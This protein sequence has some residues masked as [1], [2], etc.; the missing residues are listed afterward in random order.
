MEFKVDFDKAASDAL[1]HS[2]WREFYNAGLSAS[3]G[4]DG[5]KIT[6][7]IQNAKDRR[8]EDVEVCTLPIPKKVKDF[9]EAKGNL[10]TFKLHVPD[11]GNE[12][13]KKGKRKI[14]FSAESL[15]EIKYFMNKKLRPGFS[16]HI[17]S[18][19]FKILWR[20]PDSD[21]VYEFHN[22]SISQRDDFDR[23]ILHF[24]NHYRET[25]TLKLDVPNACLKEEKDQ[26]L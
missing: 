16:F 18:S 7:N 4:R 6:K 23:L 1:K 9:L 8:W 2:I 11:H 19:G 13:L 5:I 3:I 14:S 24:A 21:S 17:G 10:K 22:F 12:L 20:P 25:F 26:P 15:F